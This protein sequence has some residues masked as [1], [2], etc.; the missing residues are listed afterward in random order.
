MV[1][2]PASRGKKNQGFS[3]IKG[4]KAEKRTRIRPITIHIRERKHS[5]CL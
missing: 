3:L 4:L 5:K 2:T 1:P